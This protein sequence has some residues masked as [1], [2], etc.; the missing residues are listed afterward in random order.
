MSLRWSRGEITGHAAIVALGLLLVVAPLVALALASPPGLG[1]SAPVSLTVSVAD[2]LLR[3]LLLRS[4]GL[5]FVIAAGSVIIGAPLGLALALRPGTATR[6]LAALH[7][8]P[9]CLPPYLTALTWTGILGR[10]GLVRWFGSGVV[11][12]ASTSLYSP[13]GLV[14]VLTVSLSPLVT[15]LTA[16]FVRGTDASMIEAA[17]LARGPAAALRR[18]VLPA[19]LPGIALGALLV[20]V[21]AVG[22]VAVPQ[23]LRV[24]VYATVVFTR[25]AD[26][27][28]QPGEAMARSLPLLGLSVAA[29]V[30]LF[31]LDRG[32][33]S[34]QG[35]RSRASPALASSA[36]VRLAATLLAV[37]APLAA[38]PLGVLVQRAVTLPGG[39]LDAIAA[40]R[41]PLAN[42]LRHALVA[43]VLMA[44]IAI[45][46][47]LLWSRR[48]NAGAL[49]TLPALLGFVLPSV[50]L[51]LGLVSLWNRPATQWVYQGPLIVA[52]G[53]VGKYFFLPLRAAK[54][55]FDRLPRSWLDAARLHSGSPLRRALS[56]TIP[57]SA[58]VLVTAWGL[59][60]L[61]SLRDL[62][63]IIAFCPPGNDTLPIRAMTLEANAPPGLTAMAATLQIA[64]TAAVLGALIMLHRAAERRTR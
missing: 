42:S 47:G 17:M 34:T 57:A 51:S 7:V 49:V 24:P 10:S 27:S 56:I 3:G 5:A 55:G 52:L 26:L 64:L 45:P 32:G 62:E 60:F 40:L 2:P 44:L 33:R 43:S 13:L 30:G 41:G 38:L 9:L 16:A 18:V 54:L 58:S 20:F 23:L 1:E 46:G 21:F 11:Q 12:A 28:F 37:A 8:F 14:L 25:L 63:T 61:V 53:F 31:A 6:A 39:G 4:L 36:P 59:A 50:V 22:E 48:A 15:L 35:L 19:A 29:A